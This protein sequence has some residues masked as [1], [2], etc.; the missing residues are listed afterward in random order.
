MQK[1]A[2][3]QHHENIFAIVIIVIIL[4]IAFVFMVAVDRQEQRSREQDIAALDV[5]KKSQVLNFLPELKC[6]DNNNLD[7]D[8]YDILKIEAFTQQVSED[9]FYYRTLLGNMKIEIVR[10]DPSPEVNREVKRWVVYDNPK[11]EDSGY[12]LVRL[13][14]LLKDIAEDSDY[15][16][17]IYM[18]VY[19]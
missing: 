9:N 6:S 10:Y 3:L 18:R 1:K 8:C 11:A 5:V 16:G 4:A 14:V 12:T 15:F 13:P 19:R 2:Q 17:M 7:P